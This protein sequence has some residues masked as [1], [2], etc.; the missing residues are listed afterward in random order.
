[1]V[2]ARIGAWHIAGSTNSLPPT[3][4]VITTASSEDRGVRPSPRGG[5]SGLPGTG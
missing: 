5:R 2:V 4:N 3:A 1:V